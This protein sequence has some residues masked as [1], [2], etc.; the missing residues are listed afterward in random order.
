MVTTLIFTPKTP[1]CFLDGVLFR[2]MSRLVNFMENSTLIW[3][4][5]G[6]HHPPEHEC[7]RSTPPT[8]G[9]PRLHT[10]ATST[11]Q[12]S[13]KHLW[14]GRGRVQREGRGGGEGWAGGGGAGPP[15]PKPAR[16]WAA[17]PRRRRLLSL[18]AHPIHLNHI[19]VPVLGFYSLWIQLQ[20]KKEDMSEREM[21]AQ[22]PSQ[23][24][25]CWSAT[26]QRLAKSQEDRT[27]G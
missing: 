19:C 21:T 17:H 4:G 6:G 26:A 24:S 9:P 10:R 7:L 2:L 23:R 27:G 13:L 5:R 16:A 3:R 20:R 25:A 22:R 12:G 15:P 18:R 1:V 14:G 8:Q 11:L